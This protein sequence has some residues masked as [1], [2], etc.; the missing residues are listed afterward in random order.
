VWAL[1]QLLRHRL[2]GFE[3]FLNQKDLQRKK[4]RAFKNEERLFSVSSKTS[5]V[6]RNCHGFA[7][8]P[9]VPCAL[10]LT[11]WVGWCSAHG[12]CLVVGWPKHPTGRVS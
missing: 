3:G 8:A 10:V 1:L 4:S 5:P 6:V 11:C 9:S 12:T 2:Q 7:A